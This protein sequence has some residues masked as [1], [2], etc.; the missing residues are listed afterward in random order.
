MFGNG[1]SGTLELV[2]CEDT[3]CLTVFIPIHIPAIRTRGIP[4]PNPTPRSTLIVSALVLALGEGA[5]A[6][7]E[8]FEGPALEVELAVILV[9]EE[10]E[11]VKVVDELEADELAALLVMLK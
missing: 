3:L 11:D 1:F 9:V 7:S 8:A 2:L 4:I 10:V 6:A 5:G